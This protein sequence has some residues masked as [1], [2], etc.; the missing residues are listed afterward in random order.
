MKKRN[1]YK[2][3]ENLKTLYKVLIAVLVIVLILLLIFGITTQKAIVLYIALGIIT[4]EF[5][6]AMITFP[7]LCW[8]EKQKQDLRDTENCFETYNRF[9]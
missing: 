4:T 3:D 8:V 2:I 5:I 9:E 7:I 6:V 1:V